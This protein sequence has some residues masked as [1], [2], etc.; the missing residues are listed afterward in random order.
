MRKVHYVKDTKK[1]WET[2][3]KSRE[4]VDK[5][6]ESRSFTEKLVIMDKMNANHKAM[7]NAKKIA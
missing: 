3:K 1:F 4:A 2:R 5:A 6:L 7:R